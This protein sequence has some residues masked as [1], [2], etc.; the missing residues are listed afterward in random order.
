VSS[1]CPT[2]ATFPEERARS[3]FAERLINSP[4]I[5]LDRV[6]GL[7]WA[8]AWELVNAEGLALNQ[9][10]PWL[11]CEGPE[12]DLRKGL[13]FWK[14]I[15]AD[16]AVMS[17]VAYGV[18]MRFHRTP[19]RAMFPNCP[20]SKEHE[21]F[22]DAEIASHVKDGLFS[23]VEPGLVHIVNPIMV[24][25]N[26]QGK[27]RRCDDMRFCNAY[28]ASVFFK[29]M[30]LEADVPN[31][32]QPGDILFSE[33]LRKAYYKVQVELGSRKFQCFWWKGKFYM[34]SC[35]LFGFCQAPFF[36][37]KICRPLVRFFGAVLLRLINF[38][39][40]WLFS[41]KPKDLVSVRKFVLDVFRVLGWSFNEKGECGPRVTFLGFIVDSV[42]R[43]FE[44]PQPKIDA[45]ML[46]LKAALVASDEGRPL[47]ADDLRSLLGKVGSMRL[48]V[49]AIPVW[50]RSLFSPWRDGGEP[51]GGIVVTWA[52]R[53]ELVVL[54]RLL[55]TANG[56]PFVSPRWE[57]DLFVDSSEIGWGACV[58]FLQFSGTFESCLIGTSSTLR[59]LMGLLR[60][61]MVKSIEDA[62]RGK[63][64]RINMDSKPALANLT[65]G[66]GS[67]EILCTLVKYIWCQLERLG[68][69]P[70]FRW[71][72]RDSATMVRV[73]AVSKE[74][75]FGLNE[76]VRV[77]LSARF[78]CEVFFVGYTRIP[79]F[80]SSIL[81]AFRRCALVVPK[82]E[83]KSWWP[84]LVS[85]AS[86]VEPLQT[87]SVVFHG[88]SGP[89]P[90]WQFVVA[91]FDF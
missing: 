33:D 31:V 21:A 77:S 78:A 10:N 55:L 61:L 46:M 62:I 42:R 56:A 59:E 74:V 45:V 27:P 2:K 70:S 86:F 89:M 80:L 22:V 13:G 64:V 63:V 39:D 38:I 69:A 65:N 76:D 30:G 35:L 49:P 84:I 4:Q 48:A 87:G 68:A 51:A 6:E 7:S 81:A 79:N 57:V 37:T 5:K 91:L 29:M 32:V 83:A 73:D 8:E 36:F 44:V 85:H 72:S 23:V 67:V 66:G 1:F 18:P 60:C 12:F 15:G 17:Y 88:L 14:A 40:D 16:R 26:G 3:A 54:G 52:M 34:P 71:L 53:Q 11:D 75:S 41:V 50:T 58:L 24:H 82:W 25:V 9:G 90:A 43:V 19:P 20:S 47:T 28:M